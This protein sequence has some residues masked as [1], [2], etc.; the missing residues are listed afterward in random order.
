[1][2]SPDW[3]TA[4]YKRVRLD[5]R[6]AV[7]ELAGGLGVGRDP[8][9]LLDQPGAH[10]SDVVRRPAAEHLDPADRA[11]VARVHVEAAEVRGA[12]PLV[13]PAA[14]HPLGGL[15]LLEHL[16]VHERLVLAGVVRRRVDRRASVAVRADLAEVLAVGREP[17]GRD[18]GQLAV[19]EVRDRVV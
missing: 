8:G 2:V 15:G 18:R 19:V 4:T 5:D 17:V 16:L 13:E 12:E 11:Q 9:Q 14:Q 6:V 1:M 10:L 3:L 7:A